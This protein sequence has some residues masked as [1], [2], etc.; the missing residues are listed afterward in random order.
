MLWLKVCRSWRTITKIPYIT[1][2]ANTGVFKLYH[3]IG[4]ANGFISHK[5]NSWLWQYG[6][7]FACRICRAVVFCIKL[8]RIP[9]RFGE[10]VWKNAGSSRKSRADFTGIFIGKGVD[11][12]ACATRIID[13]VYGKG[14]TTALLVSVYH[15]LWNDV[16]WRN[17]DDNRSG[18]YFT[19]T[20]FGSH[21]YGK[22]F[23]HQCCKS[24]TYS[25]PVGVSFRG[26]TITK[27]VGVGGSGALWSG[28]GKVY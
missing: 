26:T 3:K 22:I 14:C 13:E 8:N 16:V 6:Y 11:E 2:C 15:Q 10:K 19:T 18:I 12:A 28:I 24:V 5:A 1:N 21:G 4:T 25:L 20:I 17:P 7:G 9:T 23:Y 27:I